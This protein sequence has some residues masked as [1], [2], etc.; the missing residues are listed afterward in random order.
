MS[1][2]LTA[3]EMKA[4]AFTVLKQAEVIN[5]K[6]N[7]TI[8]KNS[9]Y[10]SKL[11]KLI[12]KFGIGELENDIQVL[13]HKYKEYTFSY[14]RSGAYRD[15]FSKA[16]QELLNKFRKETYGGHYPGSLFNTRQTEI[17]NAMII[18]QINTEVNVDSL[19]K[20]LVAKLTK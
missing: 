19:I 20:K 3:S 2:K 15:S 4:I 12:N 8:D 9:V 1:K 16:K 11:Q 7:K 14:N 17:V 6:F 13:V 5:I 18:E 10:L